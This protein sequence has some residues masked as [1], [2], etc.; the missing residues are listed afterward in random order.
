MLVDFKISR[1]H[2]D[3]LKYRQKNSA[4]LR[5]QCIAQYLDFSF[6]FL[7]VLLG[8]SVLSLNVSATGFMHPFASTSS[9]PFKCRG[10]QN[11]ENGL[12]LLGVS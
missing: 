4:F 5:K 6:S 9:N 10:Y 1:K 11:L 7:L 8:K 2:S 12:N 3:L